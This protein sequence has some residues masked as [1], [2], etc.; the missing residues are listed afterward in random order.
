MIRFDAL[1]G[2]SVYTSLIRS[3]KKAT[4]KVKTGWRLPLREKCWLVLLY[5]Y[6]GLVRA[7]I[8]ILPFRLL[9]PRLGRCYKNNQLSPLVS[10]SQKMRAWRIGRIAELV[11]RYTPWESKCFVQAIMVRTLLGYYGIP[12][13]LHLGAMMTGET[14]IPMKAHAWVKVGPW[15]VAGREGHRAY[16]IVSTFV[17]PSVLERECSIN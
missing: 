1:P 12:Y 10:D 7:A 14:T 13:V 3:I 8:L 11:A 16:G 2:L 15:V 9:S 6:S 17:T 4:R 5:P